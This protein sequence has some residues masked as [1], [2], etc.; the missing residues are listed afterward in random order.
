MKKIL[1]NS[2]YKKEKIE[3]RKVN[4]RGEQERRDRES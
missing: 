3:E 4:R 2:K 1:E